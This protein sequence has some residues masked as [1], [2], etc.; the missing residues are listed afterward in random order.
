M[1]TQPF[2]RILLS[3]RNDIISDVKDLHPA[4]KLSVYG[5]EKFTAILD[6]LDPEFPDHITS[7]LI[8][9]ETYGKALDIISAAQHR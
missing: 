8:A 6:K 4:V 3:L 7:V 2:H 5:N 1:T 9:S